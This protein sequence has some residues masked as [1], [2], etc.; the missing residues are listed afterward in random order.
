MGSIYLRYVGYRY[1][2]KL[3]PVPVYLLLEPASPFSVG[4]GLLGVKVE[5]R[6]L[7]KFFFSPQNKPLVPYC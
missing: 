7:F 2:A 6:I 1:P 5:F 4:S 3:Y